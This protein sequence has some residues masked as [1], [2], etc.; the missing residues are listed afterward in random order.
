[1]VVDPCRPALQPVGDRL[2]P[3]EIGPPHRAAQSEAGAVGR[4]DGFVEAPV[5]Q[6][7]Q[8]RP[9]L[10]LRHH[11]AVGRDIGQ[12]RRGVEV[13]RTVQP[14]TAG[15]GSGAVGQGL[16]GVAL[17]PGQLRGVVDRAQFRAR[18][19]ARSDD[20]GLRALGEG[21]DDVGVEPG[22]GVDALDRHADLP[23]VAERR[24]EQPVRDALHVHVGQEDG[25]VVAAQLQG[26][27]AERCRRARRDG[28]SGGN[29]TGEGH[30]AD[31]RVGGQAGPEGFMAGDDREY[32]LGEGG[33]EDGSEQPGGEGCEGRGLEHHRVARGER[34]RQFRRRQLEG[35]FHGT[36]AATGPSGRQ[37]ISL[38]TGRPS[39]R[40]R[41]P[42]SSS[43]K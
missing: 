1:M 4:L 12:D 32:V 13:A 22:R 25:G 5:R 43:A 11:R 3:V 10:L 35:K 24:P 16:G 40:G 6:H 39:E 9:E 30:M 41:G 37:R 18:V 23:A 2:G 33:G 8:H 7:R 19:E 42:G 34:G 28:P 26:D 15:R 21:L 38:R 14:V 17:D 20:G 29:G 27:A 31:P 36:I